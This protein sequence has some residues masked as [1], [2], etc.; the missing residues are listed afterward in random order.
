MERGYFS[1]EFE[2]VL[3]EDWDASAPFDITHK[4]D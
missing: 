3:K 1:T 4:G 2:V